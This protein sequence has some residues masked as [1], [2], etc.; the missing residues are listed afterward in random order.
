MSTGRR[1]GAGLRG[2]VDFSPAALLASGFMVSRA[3]DGFHPSGL[4]AAS[5]GEPRRTRVHHIRGGD[6]D[7]DTAQS[8]GM[9]R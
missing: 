5:T 6:V 8:A 4:P 9:R 1:Q 7:P 3:Q 2:H